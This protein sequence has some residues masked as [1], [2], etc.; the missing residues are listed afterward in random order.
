[1]KRESCTV[2]DNGNAYVYAPTEFF[3]LRRQQF[4]SCENRMKHLMEWCFPLPWMFKNEYGPD[5]T[6]KDINMIKRTR[7]GDDLFASCFWHVYDMCTM[8]DPECW[9]AERVFK[10]IT[11]VIRSA[12]LIWLPDK[13]MDLVQLI[14][15]RVDAAVSHEELNPWPEERFDEL[16]LAAGKPRLRMAS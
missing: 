16:Y 2:S 15:S 14:S 1:M 5:L 10:N 12:T 4:R 8:E 6:M 11:R 9:Q 3:N 7:D 13:A